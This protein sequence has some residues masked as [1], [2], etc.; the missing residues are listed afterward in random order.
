MTITY[1]L[2]MSG[3]QKPS[4]I[5]LSMTDVVGM[6][7]SPVTLQ[8]E[9]F[10]WPGKAWSVTL[11]W[12]KVVGRASAEAIFA[13]LASLKGVLGTFYVGDPLGASPRGS[14]T[15][16]LVNGT[17]A[18]GASQ[19][20]T[21]GWTPSASGVLLKGDYLQLGSGTAQRLYKA[22]GDV[23]ADGSGHATIDVWP[24]I[25]EGYA[26]GAVITLTNTAGTFRLSGNPRSAKIGSPFV[27]SFQLQAT[28]AL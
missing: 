3:L 10:E 21:K 20:T 5:E 27:Y 13:F 26:D 2:S 25:R 14:G 12:D 17:V 4:Q 18:A 11:T 28:E 15:G 8:Q 7:V 24:T 23:N 16:A 1:P 19:I 6:N 9:T 22:L